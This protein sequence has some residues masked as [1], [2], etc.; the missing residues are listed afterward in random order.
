MN[1]AMLFAEWLAE[2]HY[3]L[4]NINGSGDRLWRN[5]TN[6]KTTKQLYKEF[7]KSR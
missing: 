4:F 1:K 6:Q 3:V 2:N 7:D 5:E